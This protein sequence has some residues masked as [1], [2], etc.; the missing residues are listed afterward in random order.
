[1]NWRTLL[2]PDIQ[3]F[4]HTHE[5]SDIRALAL[6][7]PPNKDWPY[8]LIIDQIKARQKARTK[9]PQWLERD[10]AI[11]P[12][13]DII[14][15]ASSTA[16]A[17]YKASLFH[18]EHFVDLTGGCGIDSWALGQ[19]FTHGT[20]I[21][22]DKGAA[23]ILRHNLPDLEIHHMS[24]EDYIDSMPQT[25]LVLIDPQR[26]TAHKRG[27]FRFEDCSPNILEILP[28]LKNKT[29]RI[30]L[31]T[32]PI[33]DIKKS[34]EHLVYTEEIHIIEWQS[35]CKELLF[36][37]NPQKDSTTPRITAISIN[38]EGKPIHQHSFTFPEERTAN[39]VTSMPQDYLFEPS[40]AFQKAGGFKTL[41]RNFDTPKLGQHTH[42]YTAKEDRPDFPGRRFKIL[43]IYPVQ[44]KALPI[45]KANLTIRNFPMDVKALKKK[46][47]LTDGG[48]DTLFACTLEDETHRLIHGQ[49]L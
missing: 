17:L 29:K 25:D 26:R 2:D 23:E 38:N 28:K 41:S 49:R 34:I 35:D 6:K 10:D 31:K 11:F 1:M 15:Q 7:K 19:S 44:A 39:L 18:G 27:L 13:S 9:M 37:L 46:L 33:L 40:P 3:F 43:G 20:V 4:V 12:P 24:A 36:I 45:H 47:K 21:E 8:A 32:S 16:T 48:E 42:L 22:R 14:E 5:D 30:A